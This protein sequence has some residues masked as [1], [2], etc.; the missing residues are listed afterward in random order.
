MVT[1][2]GYLKLV[3]Y[4]CMC[5]PAL[6]GR[7]NLEVGVEP[8]Q[9]PGRNATTLLGPDL[10]HFSS[11]VIYVALRALAA[12]PSLWLKYVEQS[13]HDKLLFR[14]DDF[15]ARG[16]SPLGQDLGRS[17][18]QDVRELAAQLF[19]LAAGPIDQVPPL[20][21]LTNSYA[22]VE[23][24]LQAQLWEEAVALLNQRGQ[25]RDAPE[26]LKPHIRYAY[27][28]V[29]R[30][31]AWRA[32]LDVPEG[33]SERNDRALIEA[34]NETLLAGFEPAEQLRPKLEEARRR[35]ATLDRLRLLI[36]ESAHRIVLHDERQMV[37]LADQLPERYGHSLSPRI[38][39][40]RQRV[41]TIARLTQAV[42]QPSGEKAILHAWRRVQRKQCQDLVPEDFAD[43]IALAERRLG[44]IELLEQQ[45]SGMPADEADRQILRVWQDGLLE[46]CPEADRWRS[47]HELAC[48]RREALERMQA[49]IDSRDEAAIAEAMADPRLTNYP[50]PAAWT[51]VLRS[52]RDRLD[53]C[54]RLVSTLRKGRRDLFGQ[55]FDARIIRQYAEQFEPHREQLVAWTRSEVLSADKLGLRPAIARASLVSVDRSQGTFRLRWT[56]PQQRFVEQCLLAVCPAEPGPEDDPTEADAHHRAPID[57][58]SWES[59]GGSRVLHSEPDWEGGFVTVWAEVN[60][61]FCVLYGEPLVLGKLDRGAK[62]G[63]ATWNPWKAFSKGRKS[64]GA[65][66]AATDPTV[67]RDREDDTR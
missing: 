38:E 43:R 48:R 62:P 53:R 36:Q 52:T 8:Y 59:A 45:P 12:D 34:W 41:T 51:A 33:F 25:F 16:A 39:R 49:A 35:A 30:Q 55:L 31:E 20:G 11:L 24:L 65:K 3:D 29:S 58:A 46:D 37:E 60:L 19:Q 6:V 13:A 40:A 54:D 50:L 21:Y 66:L 1:P 5:V 2:Q 23:A 26:H 7:R 27:E 4:D 14:T 9:H 22:K 61:G 57:R 42:L 63:V 47:A 15:L 10:D 64:P 32:V 67:S 17:P 28:H 56:W 44:L 18:D